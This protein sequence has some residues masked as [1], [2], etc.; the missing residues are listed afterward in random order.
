MNPAKIYTPQT[1]RVVPWDKIEEYYADL[2][3]HGLTLQSMLSL[4]RFIRENGFDKRL[5]A[6]TSM[7]KLVISIYDPPEWN[8]E[9]LHIE[10]DMYSK[11]IH[12]RY[13]PK[14]FRMTEAENFYPEEDVIPRFSR[15]MSH[16][17]W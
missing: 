10:F 12:F 1:A 5:Y 7:H 8:R 4:V 15:Y 2:V 3:N 11:K 13:Y 9:A 14:P 16:L 17:K 6:F